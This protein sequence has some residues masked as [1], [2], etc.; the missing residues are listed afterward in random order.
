[1]ERKEREER[2]ERE[3]EKLTSSYMVKEAVLPALEDDII[4]DVSIDQR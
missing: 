1:M 3:R 4:S 2:E